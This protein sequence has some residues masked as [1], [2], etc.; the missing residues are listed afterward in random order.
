MRTLLFVLVA[1]VSLFFCTCSG[2]KNEGVMPQC[3]SA[4]GTIT[5]ESITQ[6]GAG[7]FPQE[8]TE[9]FHVIYPPEPGCVYVEPDSSN[10]RIWY[11]DALAMEWMEQVL[12]IETDAGPAGGSCGF[13]IVAG[14][15]DPET[16][17]WQG[18]M[19][20]C[21]NVDMVYSLRH[22]G[23]ND[24]SISDKWGQ[25]KVRYQY[26]GTT[27]TGSTVQQPL[28][29]TD[30]I[31][32]LVQRELPDYD[33][34]YV[35]EDLLLNVEWNNISL[36]SSSTR[37]LFIQCGMEGVFIIREDRS[38]EFS[39]VNFFEDDLEVDIGKTMHKGVPDIQT[40]NLN[41]R[42]NIYHWNGKK[43]VLHHTEEWVCP[44]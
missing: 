39:L 3:S 41:Y 22:T 9:M 43:Y 27:Y 23:M 35:R 1:M 2:K 31:A 37:Y 15:Y 18:M 42:Y 32:V 20:E 33:Y 16:H 6:S 24:F 4:A 36:D 29:D 17:R 7:K 25:H 5:S 12:L 30:L 13:K 10:T 19:N 21:G 40:F 8:I 34:N 28:S 14:R 11:V 44:A 26:D 38:H